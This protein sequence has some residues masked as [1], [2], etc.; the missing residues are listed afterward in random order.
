MKTSQLF[1]IASP[2][3]L[4]AGCAY[5]DHGLAQY[6]DTM[7]M[8]GYITSSG[9][10]RTGID[11]GGAP[12]GNFA[13]S[14]SAAY[15]PTD[16][17]SGSGWQDVN[18]ETQVRRNLTDDSGVAA[19]APAIG[20]NV[21]GG[22]VTLSGSVGTI[23]QKQ[24]VESIA[25]KTPGVTSVDNRLQVASSAGPVADALSATSREAES[26]PAASG[27]IHDPGIGSSGSKAVAAA[28]ELSANNTSDLVAGSSS[29]DSF[30]NAPGST[31]VSN[32]VENVAAQNPQSDL[33]RIDVV[34]SDG[35]QGDGHLEA[36][37]SRSG[38]ANV[39]PGVTNS[40]P[41]EM[42]GGQTGG[43]NIQVQGTSPTD[44]T[45][46]QQINQELRT[47]ASL[48][49]AISQ[50]NVTV[51]NGRVTLRGTVK[52]EVQKREIESAIQRATGVSSV[53]NQLR[54]SS[55]SQPPLN[56]NPQP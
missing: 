15:T 52:N 37:A 7:Y 12:A 25:W 30:T 48:A 14:P 53:D 8:P 1:L 49:A 5:Q 46:A 10:S 50:V 13:S 54:V 19:L 3:I 28:D 18:L 31:A 47:D 51:A 32:H 21:N 38:Q 11:Y 17:S 4:A 41:D 16:T 29:L 9:V 23:E 26:D 56:I 27:F 24:N 44:Q 36:T 34:T 35:T 45:L 40:V 43:V 2:L 55:T 39:Y 33:N 42:I 20:I 22:V 6:D